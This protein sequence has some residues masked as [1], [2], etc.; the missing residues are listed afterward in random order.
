MYRTRILPDINDIL[1]NVS[2]IELELN[3][4]ALNNFR[5]HIVVIFQGNFKNDSE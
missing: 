2:S 3:T 5:S 4:L 1:D